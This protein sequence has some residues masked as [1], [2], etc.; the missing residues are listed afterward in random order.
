[1]HDTVISLFMAFCCWNCLFDCCNDQHTYVS[2]DGPRI[3]HMMSKFQNI[4]GEHLVLQPL[5]RFTYIH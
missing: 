5:D 4:P 2:V 1:M 3:T